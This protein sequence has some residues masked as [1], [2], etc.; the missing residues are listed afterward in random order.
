MRYI[1]VGPRF[2]ATII[3]MIVLFVIMYVVAIA[4]GNTTSSG[5][6]M[7]GAPAFLGFGVWVLYYIG[8]EA[9]IGATLGKLVLAIRVV[10]ED[11]S[12]IGWGPA[13]IRNLLRIVDGFFVY[14][15]GAILIWRSPKRQRLGDR[16]AGTVVISRASQP[17]AETVAAAPA[18]H[19]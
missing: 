12:P 15:V 2:A 3:D 8:L 10:K 14:L 6:S 1:G 9:T 18:V 4:T 11:G 16:L 19:V 7:Q 13:V 17:V 5:F